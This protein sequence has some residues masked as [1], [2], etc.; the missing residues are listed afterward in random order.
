MRDN[1]WL[2]LRFDFIWS[3]YFPKLKQTNPLQIRFGRFSKYRLGSIKLNRKT[4]RSLITIT[5]MFKDHK[6]PSYVVD[7]TLAHEL[8]HYAH[9][10]SSKRIRLH[11]YPHAGGIVRKEM[12]SRGLGHLTGAYKD[13]VKQ[14]RIKLIEHAR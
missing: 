14:Y 11:K 12:E 6:I 4:N 13:W 9:G 5:S 8:I 1:N 10:F 3:K 7:H 2:A